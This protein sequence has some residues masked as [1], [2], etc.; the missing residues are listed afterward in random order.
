MT[1]LA[2]LATISGVFALAFVAG[3]GA[4]APLSE[5]EKS[6]LV[7]ADAI[8]L[9][10]PVHGCHRSCRIGRVSSWGGAARAHRHVG[11]NCKLV[12]CATYI[13]G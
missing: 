7:A 9:I 8:S 3:T 4:T 10:E 5:G 11:P 12:R 1:K 2:L 13:T 6:T